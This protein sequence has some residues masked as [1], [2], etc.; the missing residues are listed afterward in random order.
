MK[1]N[2]FPKRKDIFRDFSE[3]IF[4]EKLYEKYHINKK[5]LI[6]ILNENIKGNY[7][8]ER[9]LSG[10]L[11]AQQQFLK[12]LILRWNPLDPGAPW[13]NISPYLEE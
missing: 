8:Y 12:H 4:Y 11:I 5:E 3:G 2:Q 10:G 9:I 1:V 6:Q 13:E 7:D